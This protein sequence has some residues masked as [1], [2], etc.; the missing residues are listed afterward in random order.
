MRIAEA[1]LAELERAIPVTRRH[2]ERVPEDR[3]DWRP[4]PKSLTLGQLALHIAES[5]GKVAQLA[6]QDVVALPPSREF[7]QPTSV[8][9]V[10]DALDRSLNEARRAL[11]GVDDERLDRDVTFTRGGQTL[12]S[13]P[14]K[15]FLRDIMLNHLYHHRGQLTVYLREL[16]VPVPPS[17]G[18]TA[19]EAPTPRPQPSRT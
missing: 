15:D 16:D 11:E 13:Y 10:L 19:D 2:L 6:L 7:P 14:R 1:M 17:F 8:A 3:L 18:P 9:E 5:S 12:I 4:T